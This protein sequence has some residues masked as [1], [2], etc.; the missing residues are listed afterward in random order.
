MR[1]L[2]LI[3]DMLVPSTTICDSLF[4][5]A[6]SHLGEDVHQSLKQ[7]IIL[8]SYISASPRNVMVTGN[9][10]YDKI[11]CRLFW[12]RQLRPPGDYA[13]KGLRSL[14]FRWYCTNNYLELASK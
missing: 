3:R 8:D 1:L 12:T 9:H 11:G 2:Y 7:Q 13:L 4:L 6:S 14:P 10:L 5:G